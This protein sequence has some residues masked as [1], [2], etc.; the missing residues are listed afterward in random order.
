MIRVG[1]RSNSVCKIPLLRA[2]CLVAILCFAVSS[3]AFAQGN[4]LKPSNMPTID[5]NCAD[6]PANVW[7]TGSLDKVG[8]N[9]GTAPS[10]PGTYADKWIVVYGTQNEFVDFQVHWHDTG[11]GTTGLNVTVSSF[12]QTSPSSYTIQAPSSTATD[13]VVYREA[14]LDIT[15]PSA[16]ALTGNPAANNTYLGTGYWPDVLIPNI[17]PYYHQTTNAWPFTVAAGQNQSAWIDVHVPKAAPAGYYK[18]TVTVQT[19]CPTSCT[20]VATLPIILG[21]WQWPASSGGSMPSTASITSFNWDT[22]WDGLCAQAYGGQCSNYPGAGGNTSTA[23]ELMLID[24]SILFLDHRISQLSVNAIYGSFDT[25]NYPP[26]LNGTASRNILQGAKLQA[27]DFARGT[28]TSSNAQT[29]ATLFNSNGWSNTLFNYSCD[30]PPNGCAWSAITG[31]ATVDHGVT[32]PIPALVTVDLADA[33]TN[34]VSTSVDWMVSIINN[35]DPVGGSNQRSS[36]NSWL[37]GSSGPTR[38]LWIYQSCESEACGSGNTNTYNVNWPDYMIDGTPVSNRAMGWMD[39]YYQ[40]SG[41]LYYNA[42]ICWNSG[43]CPNNNDPWTNVYYS[44]G[45][46]DGTM[47]YPGRQSGS[48]VGPENVGTTYPIWLPSIRLKNQRDG[49]QD[50][51]YLNLL[52]ANGQGTLVANTVASWITNGH[53]YNNN[54]T[55]AAGVYTSDLTD[56]RYALGTAMN[57][58]TYPVVLLPP[59]SLSGTLQQ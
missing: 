50:Y 26:L 12:V 48:T 14:Y 35:M 32:P 20:T 47:L 22:N 43:Y 52:N 11:S 38:R 49:L 36:Y 10:C 57:Q 27:F 3:L 18:G 13:I 53:A 45:N 41:D 8:Q 58:L 42:T 33:T 46:G 39:Y 5:T 56:A 9:S 28:T 16:T 37:A 25:T 6:Y 55:A 1:T 44:G 2:A 19:G 54:P 17:D 30:E 59:A 40:V 15:T 29:Y 7:V 4:P 31:N 34:G 24:E 51:E 23:E 21:V